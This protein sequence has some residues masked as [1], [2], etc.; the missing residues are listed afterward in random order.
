MSSQDL[1][2]NG[3]HSF[4]RGMLDDSTHDSLRK[5][6]LFFWMSCL[7][8]SAAVEASIAEGFMGGIV[9]APPA[10]TSTFASPLT[11]RCASWRSAESKV[12]PGELPIFETVLFMCKTMD[13]QG[14]RQFSL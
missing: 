8:V 2:M 4:A 9:M 7:A 3:D 1:A 6:R 5:S 11:L 12:T 14:V 10:W 13:H